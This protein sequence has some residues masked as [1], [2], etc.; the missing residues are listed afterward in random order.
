[1][2]KLTTCFGLLFLA[3]SF[4]SAALTVYVSDQQ[5]TIWTRTGPSDEY[6]VWKQ[7]A[8]GTKLDQIG[9]DQASGYTQVKDERGGEFWIKSEMLTTKATANYRL[10][11]LTKQMNEYKKQQQ[12]KIASLQKQIKQL[13]PLQAR[14]QE[15]QQKLARLET[16][17]EQSRQKSQVYQSGFMSEVFIAGA[18]VILTGMLFGWLLGKVAGR[19]RDSGWR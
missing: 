2:K 16:D 1:M 14:N 8:P 10:A 18:T 13:S 5:K 7:L 3:I 17:L 6:R 19:K 9:V 12:D 15:L 11:A 4:N